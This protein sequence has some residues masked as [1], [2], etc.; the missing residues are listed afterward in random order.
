MTRIHTGKVADE[1][2]AVVIDNGSYSIKV[3]Y[4]GAEKPQYV[5]RSLAA[6]SDGTELV[7]GNDSLKHTETRGIMTPV[8]HGIVRNWALAERLWM[9][10]FQDQLKTSQR[11]HPILLTEPPQ[12]PKLHRER[13]TQLFFE[14]F[15][16]PGL[17]MAPTSL[18]AL[19]GAC[20]TTGFVVDIG[21]GIPHAVPVYEGTIVP[22]AIER[23]DVGGYDLTS[24][25]MANIEALDSTEYSSRATA[26]E[27]KEK[28]C[29]VVMNYEQEIQKIDKKNTTYTLPDGNVVNIGKISIQCPESILTPEVGGFKAPK[30]AEVIYR[31]IKNCHPDM[32]K[33]LF[34]NIVITG[35]SSLFSGLLERCEKDILKVVNG[36]ATI[37]L[38]DDV[39]NRGTAVWTGG[40]IVASL[41]TFQH[42]WVTKAEYEESGPTVIHRKCF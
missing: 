15:D 42:M 1:T 6:Y 9:H 35:G 7:V 30:L 28:C 10:A 27:I 21:E 13:C 26:N 32:H 24:L 11:E 16:I 20:R 33:I 18:L 3:G 39:K 31:A 22:H 37:K 17:Y 2:L 34:N 41:S 36:N 25:V 23:L 29:K 14:V 40:S 19:Y 4:A 38:I 8:Q 5:F 12:N